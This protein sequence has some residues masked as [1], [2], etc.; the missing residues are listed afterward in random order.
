MAFLTIPEQFD[1]SAKI[2]T[3]A[4]IN[5]DLQNGP[6]AMQLVCERVP[7]LS[8]Y[9]NVGYGQGGYGQ[10]GYGGQ[11]TIGTYTLPNSTIDGDPVSLPPNAKVSMGFNL[12][13]TTQ[14]FV[15]TLPI[16]VEYVEIG[17]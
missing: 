7:V 15:L 11:G 1:K 9:S 4:A 16:K 17:A 13:S 8:G 2:K 10:G 3:F 12:S 14:D 6:L 5:Y